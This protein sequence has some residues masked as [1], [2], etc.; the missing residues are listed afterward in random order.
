LCFYSL[1]YSSFSSFLGLSKYYSY[2]RDTITETFRLRSRAFCVNIADNRYI[3]ITK[4]RYP[5]TGNLLGFVR[6]KEKDGV[7]ELTNFKARLSRATLD[8]GIIFKREKD[9]LASTH[10]KGFKI[11][12]LVIVYKGY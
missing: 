2:R 12:A 10:G 7:L 6:Y 4:A 8:L 9:Y 3:Y 11:T 5:N 1:K